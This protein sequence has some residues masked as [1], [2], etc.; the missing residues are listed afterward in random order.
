MSLSDAVHAALPALVEEI[1]A[2]LLSRF[3]GRSASGSAP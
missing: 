2:F 3:E 1:E